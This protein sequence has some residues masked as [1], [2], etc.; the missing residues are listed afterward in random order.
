MRGR[1]TILGTSSAIP[2]KERNH[3]AVY[4]QWGG[5]AFLFDCGEGTQ[6]QIQIAELSFYKIDKIFVTHLHGDHVLGL[7]GLLQTL[8]FHDK[9]YVEVLILECKTLTGYL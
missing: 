3:P 5:E 6:R 8:D 9:R 7:P 2:T 1:F 4:F